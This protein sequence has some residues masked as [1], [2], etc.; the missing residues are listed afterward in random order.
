MNRCRETTQ[1]G[2]PPGNRRVLVSV[3]EWYVAGAVTRGRPEGRPYPWSQQV[4]HEKSRLA[5]DLCSIGRYSRRATSRSEFSAVR[6][7]RT[8]FF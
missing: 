8:G 1:M 4:I 6:F 3:P 7:F 5:G 2:V